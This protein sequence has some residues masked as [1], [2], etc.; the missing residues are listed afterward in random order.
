MV[1]EGPPDPPALVPSQLVLLPN[2][3]TLSVAPTPSHLDLITQ[4]ESPVAEGVPLESVI[5]TPSQEISTPSRGN[6]QQQRL[7]RYFASAGTRARPLLPTTTNPTT[8]GLPAQSAVPWG[9]CHLPGEAVAAAGLFRVYSQNVNGLSTSNSNLEVHEFAAAMSKKSVAPAAMQETN[10]NFERPTVAQAFHDC[11]RN[12]STH[13][14]GAV[15]SARLQFQSDYQPGGTAVA[16]L[17]KWATR[18]LSKG[19]DS[20]GRWS[21]I[22]LVGC[23]T[24]KITFISAYR[25][26][27]GASYSNPESSTVRSQLEWMNASHGLGHV[28]VRHQFDSALG[29]LVLDFQNNGHD[30][31]LMMDANE[32][33]GSDSFCD[34]LCT[35]C[36]LT[37]AH[38]LSAD[39]SPPP[40]TFA[41]G[42]AQIDFVLISGRLISAVCAAS[43]LALC[44]GVT[45]DHRALVVDFDEKVLFLDRTSEVIAPSSRRLTSTQ[46]KAVHKYIKNMLAYVA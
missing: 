33:D 13:H 12:V 21:W 35:R 22:T 25:V 15:A 24:L 32:K 36:C 45:S 23:G 16:V 7:S 5:P 41:M 17:N 3:P 39:P 29:D 27:N 14:Q 30:I 2:C 19:S 46:P 42:S 1:G 4:P 44:D 20:Y 40:A 6:S 34:R 43:I 38:S 10:R 37:D 8:T 28:Q 18:F 31:V 9:D 26:C 11:F